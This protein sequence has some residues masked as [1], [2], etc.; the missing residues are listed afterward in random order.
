MTAIKKTIQ[1]VAGVLLCEGKVLIARRKPG[2]ILAGYWEFPG[3]KIE[4]GEAPEESLQRELAEEFDVR[5]EVG[6]FL[7]TTEHIYDFGKVVLH[8]YW[9]KPLSGEFR[10][11]DHDLIAWVEPD[12]L[13]DR[14]GEFQLAPADV[15]LIAII[16]R[17]KR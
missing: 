1:V 2:K 6:E 12:R 10:L 7:A 16:E 13:R 17:L 3:G 8:A 4:P 15:P 5:V 9:A 11:V 14:L